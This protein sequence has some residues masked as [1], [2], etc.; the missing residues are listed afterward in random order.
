MPSGW[1]LRSDEGDPIVLRLPAGAVKTIGR[2]A[3]ADFILE[4][5][6]VSRVHCRL[7]AD[8]SQQLI[9]E[10][11]EST[12][13]TLVNG[14]RMDRAVLKAGDRLTVGR[15]EFVVGVDQDAE[16]DSVN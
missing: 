15:V 13:G 12:N 10:D 1:I 5:A 3:Q 11:L 14:E 7:S 16:K 8:P 4:A 6:L 9:M 2:G